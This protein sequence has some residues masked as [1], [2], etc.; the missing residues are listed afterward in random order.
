[1]KLVILTTL[2]LA[3]LASATPAH[4][5]FGTKTEACSIIE[6]GHRVSFK[7]CTIDWAMTFGHASYGVQTPDGRRFGI[8]NDVTFQPG[9][10]VF[11]GNWTLDGKPAKQ[12]DGCYKNRRVS[13]CF[14]PSMTN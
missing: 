12:T 3:T 9:H 10:D 1:M 8:Q 6:H 5:E 2:A 14:D 13:I 4:A 11:P 7:G